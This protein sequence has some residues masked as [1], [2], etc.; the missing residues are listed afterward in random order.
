MWIRLHVNEL[1]A[2]RLARNANPLALVAAAQANQDQYYQTSRSDR[3]SSPSSKPSIPSRSHTSTKHKGKEIAKPITPLSETAFEEDNDPEQAQRDKDMEKNLALI[4]KY[5][6]KI[7]KPT[8]NN[9]KTS[10]NSTNKNVDMTPRYKNDDHSGRFGNQRTVNVA[11]AREKVGRR[12]QSLVEQSSKRAVLSYEDLK[13]GSLIKHTLGYK[14]R[15]LL[16]KDDLSPSWMEASEKSLLEEIHGKAQGGKIKKSQIGDTPY[17]I[18]EQIVFLIVR[19]DPNNMLLERI[20]IRELGMIPS[21]MHSVVLYQSE[22][23]PRVIISE[24][25][26][27]KR[28]EQTLK[29]R[30]EIF[31]T[32]HRLNENKKITPVQQK[33]RGMALERRATSAKEVKELR[34]AGIQREKREKPPRGNPWEGAGRKNKEKPDRGAH[35]HG[36]GSQKPSKEE[37]AS[38]DYEHRRNNIT[39]DTKQGPICGPNPH[40]HSS[41]WETS[42]RSP[43]GQRSS[44]R[45][46]ILALLPKALKRNQRK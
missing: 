41:A 14:Q 2:E 26:D 22:V 8:N 20:A 34:K 33:K 11:G 31:V 38:E 27:I 45:R 30:D 15:K 1:R 12:S 42:R 18:G 16:Q 7:Y 46:H 28:C 29:I 13:I 21:T 19:S 35:S 17:Y 37:R 25:Q 23:R 44:L 6:T 32:E 40:K 39:S 4:P 9:L 10:S 24:Y 3:S 36:K 43:P 5:F